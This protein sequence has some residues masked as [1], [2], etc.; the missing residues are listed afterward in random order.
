MKTDTLIK[1]DTLNKLIAISKKYDVLNE[2]FDSN[3]FW[4]IILI[5]IVSGIIGGFVN[6]FFNLKKDKD[7]ESADSNNLA[8]SVIVGIGASILVPIFLEI[9]QSRILDG[10]KTNSLNDHIL[11]ISFCVLAAI[12]STRFITSVSDSV[13]SRIGKAEDAAKEAKQKAET[14]IKVTEQRGGTQKI[15]ETTK[16]LI[17]SSNS[18]NQSEDLDDPCK[19]EFGGSREDENFKISVDKIPDSS[20]KGW[21]NL[22]F[23]VVA[24]NPSK[25]KLEG[26]VRFHLHPTF[27]PD[28]ETVEVVNG[29]AKLNK[30]AWGAFTIGVEILNTGAKLELD[31]MD[32][33]DLPDDFK[34]R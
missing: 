19:G 4:S 13:L 2:S 9:T 30:I 26:Q 7:N 16:R 32:E 27:K 1:V 5:I 21:Y 11:F 29:I 25:I 34:K 3:T 10:L 8:R 22:T 24:K 15:S 33:P 23:K 28:V 20:I 6:Y 17:E 12:T 31:L 18:E 14:L